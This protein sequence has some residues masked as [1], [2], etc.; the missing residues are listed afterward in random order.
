[1]SVPTDFSFPADYSCEPLEEIPG[2]GKLK[3]YFFPGDTTGGRDGVLVRVVPSEGESWLGTFAFGALRTGIDRILSM[4]DPQKLCVIARGAGYVVSARM[5]MFW[6][7]V[8]ALPIVDARVALTAGVVVFANLT[9]MVAYGAEGLRWRTRRLAW[10]GLKILE[11]TERSIVGEYWDM[12][13]ESMQK[14]EVAL[15][16]GSQRGGVDG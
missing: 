16:T 14:F 5:P 12:R 10:D 3:R 15:E 7:P 13:Q 1:M 2:D 11:V 6:E 4:A 8:K 9:E